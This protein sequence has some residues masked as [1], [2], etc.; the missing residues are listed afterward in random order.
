VIAAVVRLDIGSGAAAESVNAERAVA[1]FPHRPPGPWL[2]VDAYA[3][4]DVSAEMWDLPFP[5]GSVD[6]IWS[7]HALEHV[8]LADVA[9]TLA[10][11]FRVLRPGGTAVIQVPDF[12]HAAR[13][14]LDN[15]GA[16]WAQQ[17][18]WGMQS[19]AGDFHRCGWSEETFRAELLAAGFA[20]TVSSVWDYGQQT[21]RAEVRKA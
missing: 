19:H 14:W 2:N 12:A 6:E 8:A 3:P 17:L 10:E 15:P 21:L 11:W 7:S 1:G 9:R 4:A 20:G 5:D 16:R 18:V 13:Y